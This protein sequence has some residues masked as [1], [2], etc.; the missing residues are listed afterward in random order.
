[1]IYL[2]D[3]PLEVTTFP[4][5]TSQVWKIT[6]FILKN[7]SV[8]VTWEFTSEAEFMHL[9][10][11]K[12]LL[13]YYSVKARLHITYLPYARQDK[14]ISNTTTFDEIRKQ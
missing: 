14:P 13:D 3:L 6:D 7:K 1:M 5:G 11:L 8:N 10:Q 4:D 2:N 9:A 12:D